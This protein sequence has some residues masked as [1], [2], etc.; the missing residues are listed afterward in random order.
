MKAAPLSLVLT[1]RA[2][3]RHT[4]NLVE[5]VVLVGATGGSDLVKG[6]MRLEVFSGDVLSSE[7]RAAVPQITGILRCFRWSSLQERVC[8]RGHPIPSSLRR[9]I[10]DGSSVAGCRDKRWS[11]VYV[12]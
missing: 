4:F 7:P 2:L 11:R 10:S 8:G 6:V 9:A 1:G 3:N 12:L 5:V